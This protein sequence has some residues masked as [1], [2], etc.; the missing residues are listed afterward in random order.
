DGYLNRKVRTASI[1]RCTRGDRSMLPEGT[2][3]VAPGRGCRLAAHRRIFPCVPIRRRS[4]ANV[5]TGMEIA[6]VGAGIAGLSAAWR[7]SARH[8]VTLIEKL[9]VAGMDAHSIDL[10][11]DGTSF[12]IDVPLR[13]LYEGYYPTLI[14]LYS[15]LG[16]ETE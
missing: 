1:G 2:P 10:P 5:R 11:H 14:A 3:N 7:L 6:V 8:R 9:P 13:V 4:V 12:R 15:A 16:V